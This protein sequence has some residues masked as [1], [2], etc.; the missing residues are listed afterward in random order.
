MALIT[1]TEGREW[2]RR[3]RFGAR[4]RPEHP[5][6]STTDD[7]ECFFSVLRD[8]IGQNFLT[9]EVKYG[10]CKICSEFTKRLDPDLPF[11]LITRQVIAAIM[12]DPF[13]LL[14]YHHKR[15]V[16]RTK[17][18]LEGNSQLHLQPV[19]QLCLLEGVWQL[20]LNSIMSP[21]NYPHHRLVLYMYSNTPMHNTNHFFFL[22]LSSLKTDSTVTVQIH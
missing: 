16:V 8:S 11:F 10:F 13:Q 12:K 7:I 18:Y 1:N 21:L 17:G 5:R 2:R 20:D 19:V 3:K 6:T 14:M 15:P 22:Y 9:K 4:Q